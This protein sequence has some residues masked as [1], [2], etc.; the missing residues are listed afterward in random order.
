MISINDHPLREIN[1]EDSFICVDFNF[2]KRI[3]IVGGVKGKV[4]VWKFTLTSNII[5][6]S[7][8]SLEPYCAL[9]S[10]QGISESVGAIIW[11]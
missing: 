1:D 11:V 5:P 7:S 2:R 4:Y 8:E 3:L 10:I 6:V 9:E